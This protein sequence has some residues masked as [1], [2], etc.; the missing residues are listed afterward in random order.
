MFNLDIIHVRLSL[1]QK[2]FPS[3]TSEKLYKRFIRMSQGFFHYFFLLLYSFLN[4]VTTNWTVFTFS[5]YAEVLEK[6]S[7]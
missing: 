4:F 1:Y 3:N 5:R 7:I 2:M 6:Q